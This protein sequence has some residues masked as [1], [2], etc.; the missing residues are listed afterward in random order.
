[1]SVSNRTQSLNARTVVC[2]S[3]LLAAAM[4][5]GLSGCTTGGRQHRAIAGNPTPELFSMTKRQVDY[6]NMV[7]KTFNTNGRA[8]WDDISRAALLNRPS[9]LFKGP[10]PF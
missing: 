5:S 8:A 3:A 1:M 2:V 6:D 4:V 10:K 9:R 7:V